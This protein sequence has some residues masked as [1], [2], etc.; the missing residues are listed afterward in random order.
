M[1]LSVGNVCGGHGFDLIE[2]QVSQPDHSYQGIFFNNGQVS[3]F[4]RGQNVGTVMDAV[5][6][7]AGF[8]RG[9][10]DVGHDQLGRIFSWG[11]D[12][13]QEIAFREDAKHI[14]VIIPND[15]R[16]DIVFRHEAGCFQNSG[17]GACHDYVG[18]FYHENVFNGC[19]FGF[20]MWFEVLV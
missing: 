13:A 15:D 12:A 16:A 8:Y 10:H 7:G 6:Q 2:E 11:D 1:I 9:R 17:C 14:A 20:P 3:D 18:A 19:H 5:C 4:R